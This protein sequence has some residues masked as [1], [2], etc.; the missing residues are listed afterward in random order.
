MAT[1]RSE[2]S[3]LVASLVSVSRENKY[4]Q[5]TPPTPIMKVS[6]H[7]LL[8]SISDLPSNLTIPAALPIP[9]IT[10]CETEIVYLLVGGEQESNNDLNFNMSPI[11]RIATPGGKKGQMHFLQSVLPR[12]MTFIESHLSKRRRVCVACETGA[13]IGVGVALAALQ[14]FFDDDGNFFGHSQQTNSR[15]WKALIPLIHI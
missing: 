9:S 13:D 2:L 1:S 5:E 14:K 10:S 4:A 7:I 11:L 12:S 15:T 8:C 6:G 3:D